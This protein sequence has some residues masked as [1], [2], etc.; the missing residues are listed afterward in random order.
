[1]SQSLRGQVLGHSDVSDQQLSVLEF[2]LLPVS[3]RELACRHFQLGSPA[4]DHVG[5]GVLAVFSQERF[6]LV[7]RYEQPKGHVGRAYFFVDKRPEWQS[8]APRLPNRL[9]GRA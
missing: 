7:I 2:Q 9:A 4:P 8:G 6:A 1:M 5:R 3:S